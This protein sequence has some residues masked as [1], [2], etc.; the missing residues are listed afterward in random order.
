MTPDT[1]VYGRLCD[2]VCGPVE[3]TDLVVGAKVKF[4]GE[5]RR[6]TV[7]AANERFAV[8]T[9]PAFGSVMY[10]IVDLHRGVRG[11]DNLIFGHGWETDEECSSGLAD[12]ASGETEV[13]HR[14][15]VPLDIEDV[16]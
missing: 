8:C 7:R 16:R 4:A 10:T 11:V 12:L 5:K 3:R 14:N 6:Y 2:I 9:K 1:T 15:C 13:S